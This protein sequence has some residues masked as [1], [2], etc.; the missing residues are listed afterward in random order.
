MRCAK[1]SLYRLCCAFFSPKKV[2][3]LQT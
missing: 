2:S 3:H 1:H